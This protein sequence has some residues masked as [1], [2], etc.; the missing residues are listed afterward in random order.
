MKVKYVDGFRQLVLDGENFLII[1]NKK[2]KSCISIDKDSID[3][4]VEKH[5]V[6]IRFENFYFYGNKP[7]IKE[8]IEIILKI[9]TL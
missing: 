1:P 3:R 4:M 7:K 9:L 6:T 5:G 8:K 2:S